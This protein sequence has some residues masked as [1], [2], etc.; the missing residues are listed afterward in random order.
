MIS[1][2]FT[3]ILA[4]W[5]LILSARVIALRGV[6][7]LKFFSFNNFG[8]KAL[9]RSVRAQGNFIEYTPFFLILLFI[10]EF[11]GL[12]PHFLYLVSCLFLISRLMHGI[13]LGFMRHSPFLRG[14]GTVLTFVSILLIA[15][16]N[17]YEVIDSF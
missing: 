15:M 14:W 13:G 2:I 7:F 9:S 1:T 8:E 10:A 5:L 3:S 16:F 11:N 6:S 4:I 17:V 12:H